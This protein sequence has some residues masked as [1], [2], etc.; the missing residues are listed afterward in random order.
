MFVKSR[1]SLLHPGAAG[2]I[3]GSISNLII[4]VTQQPSC[5]TKKESSVCT[6]RFQAQ[7]KS[8]E[9]GRG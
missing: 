3:R 6:V 4:V 7:F 8:K 9:S 1:A 2:E 5:E